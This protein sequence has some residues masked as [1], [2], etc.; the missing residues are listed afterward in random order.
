[1]IS[2]SIAARLGARPL[3]SRPWTLAHWGR[4]S[5][6]AGRL[7]GAGWRG[8]PAR[9]I[10]CQP[11]SGKG[12]RQAIHAVPLAV[13]AHLPAQLEF[14]PAASPL[15]SIGSSQGQVPAAATERLDDSEAEIPLT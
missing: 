1:M 6:G 2:L 10:C 3:G 7:L 9:A 12:S 14:L 13:R 8:M 11:D 15:V 4:W 5:L